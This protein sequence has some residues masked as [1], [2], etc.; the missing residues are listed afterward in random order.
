MQGKVK[1]DLSGG[2]ARPAA[3][4][5]MLHPI[6]LTIRMHK[7]GPDRVPRRIAIE[8][9]PVSARPKINGAPG[10]VAMGERLEI[11]GLIDTVRVVALIVVTVNPTIGTLSAAIRPIGLRVGEHGGGE[12]ARRDL[13]TNAVLTGGPRRIVE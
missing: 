13:I 11:G 4:D 5:P 1:S 7:R 3:N 2:S 9:L 8:P 12:G 6:I 10:T